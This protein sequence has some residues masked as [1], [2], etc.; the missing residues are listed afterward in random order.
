MPLEKRIT[1][2]TPV[3][4]AR[5]GGEYSNKFS[6][7]GLS[8]SDYS[9]KYSSHGPSAGVWVGAG[10]EKVLFLILRSGL[11]RVSFLNERFLVAR[12]MGCN[13]FTLKI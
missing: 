1:P 9:A 11:E 7:H 3:A 10:P 8:G 12:G 5:Q 13:S 6:R 4:I 2:K